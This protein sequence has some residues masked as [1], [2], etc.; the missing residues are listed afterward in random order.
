L[1]FIASDRASAVKHHTPSATTAPAPTKLP[2]GLRLD[3]NP[4]N[5]QKLFKHLSGYEYS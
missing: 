1:N 4:A 3:E 5:L 2:S